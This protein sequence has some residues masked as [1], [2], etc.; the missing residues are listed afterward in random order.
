MLSAA[1]IN[2]L[3]KKRAWILLPAAGVGILAMFAYFALVGY[4][5]DW[6]VEFARQH[7]GKIFADLLPLTLICPSVG[8]LLAPLIWGERKS[9]RYAL[10]CPNCNTD[11]S[12]FTRRVLATRFCCSCGTQVVEGRRTH[13]AKA[14]ERFS[15]MKQRRFL[16]Y[17]FWTWP[18]LGLLVLAYYQFDRA[19]ME[20]C[21]HMLFIPGLI[22]I[23]ATGWAFA[24]TMDTRY[25]PQLAASALVFCF[26]VNAF[27]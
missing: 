8:F 17:W 24:R 13:G 3:S 7:V 26:G 19:A 22:G 9:K 14:F 16:I 10:I 18:V 23:V 21:P 12:R 27:W 1:D 6:L 11:I 20:N 15:R 2:D 4:C 25:L 5:R